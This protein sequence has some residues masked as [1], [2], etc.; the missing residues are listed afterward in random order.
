MNM[1]D[2]KAL[3]ATGA[4]GREIT[5]TDDQSSLQVRKSRNGVVSY[6]VRWMKAEPGRASH[7]AAPTNSPL[8]K[9]EK[10][11]STE[12]PRSGGHCRPLATP[13]PEKINHRT[14]GPACL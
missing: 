10:P 6:R 9:Q 14:Y 2:I 11:P 3:N 12:S 4:D 7:L 5:L 13:E 8:R 1:N